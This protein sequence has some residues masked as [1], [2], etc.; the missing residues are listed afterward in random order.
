MKA[1]IDKIRRILQSDWVIALLLTLFFLAIKGYR[2]AWDDQHLEIPLLKSLINPHLYPGDYYVT[3]LKNNF[4]SYFYIILSKLIS[5]RQVEG[6]YLVLYLISR[7]FLFF[8]MYKFWRLVTQNRWISC[9]CVLILLSMGDIP[10]FLYNTFSHQEFTLAIVFAGIYFFYRKKFLLASAI[11]GIGTNF[12]ALYS[13]YPMTFIGMYLL[14]N[15]RKLGLKPLLKSAGAYLLCALPILIWIIQR[16]LTPQP[17]TP[18]PAST[19]DWIPLYK[20]ACLQTFIFEGVS[21]KYIFSNFLV[22]VFHAKRYLFLLALFLLNYL[23][24]ETFRKDQKVQIIALTSLLAWTITYIFT[25]YFPTRF[26]LDLNLV[27]YAQ[28]LSFFLVGY[29]VFFVLHSLKREKPFSAFLIIILFGFLSYG[30]ISAFLSLSLLTLL[31]SLRSELRHPSKKRRWASVGLMFLG[32]V[33]LGVM[34]GHILKFQP[35]GKIILGISVLVLAVI[36]LIIKYVPWVRK[37][38]KTP[39]YLFILAILI[40]IFITGVKT[41]FTRNFIEEK[42]QTG[43]WKLQRDWKNIQLYVRDHTPQNAIFM[44]PYDTEMGGFRILSERSV[45]CCYRDCG[46]I[47]F[48]LNAAWEWAKRVRE[49]EPFKVR[50]DNNADIR[51]AMAVGVYKYRVNYL[52][53]MRYYAPQAEASPNFKKVYENDNFSLFEIKINPV[54]EHSQ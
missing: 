40:A 39:N 45:I 49:I 11:L 32:L 15:I 43:F 52:I 23:H 10:E 47:G 26:V 17:L 53:F 28:Y 20:I 36:G 9:V 41:H 21:F 7:Y 31:L 16:R 35:G 51:S 13:L 3:S 8:F 12:H 33:F 38:L 30:P 29:T 1:A 42:S 50:L 37:T 22:W 2:Y 48:D 6:A 24:N 27:R 5:T 25:F 18:P 54:P 14:L 34:T 44:T 4:I 19:L 46:I